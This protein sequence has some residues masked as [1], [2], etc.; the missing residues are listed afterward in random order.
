MAWNDVSKVCLHLGKGRTWLG[1]EKDNFLDLKLSYFIYF[2]FIHL[3]SGTMH[4]NQHHSKC[5]SVS[6]KAHFPSAVPQP[7]VKL[8][9]K[10]TNKIHNI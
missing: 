9:I 8:D 5:A 10:T 2:L 6:K 7:D 1:L 3:F 4:M